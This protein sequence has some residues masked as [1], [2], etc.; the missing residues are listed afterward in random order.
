MARLEDLIGESPKRSFVHLIATI[1][2]GGA[3]M[4]IIF[5]PLKSFYL[6]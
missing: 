6:K 3:K 2:F 1:E 4:V 5:L